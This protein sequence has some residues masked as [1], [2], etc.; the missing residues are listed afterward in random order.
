MSEAININEIKNTIPHRYPFLLVDRVVD[1]IKGES[2]VGIKNFTINE[3]FFLGHFPDDPIVPGV[4]L[5]EAMA[6]TGAILVVKSLDLNPGS[7]GVLF[8]ALESVKFKKSVIPGDTFK[9]Q[10]KIL[11]IKMGFCIIEGKGFVDDNLVVDGTFSAL[12]YDKN[13][14]VKK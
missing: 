1:L 8:S 6:Q 7:T 2:C 9:M 5:L 11:K 13:K 10:V 12:V 3:E 4:L 14:K